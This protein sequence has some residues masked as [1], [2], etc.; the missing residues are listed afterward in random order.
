[1]QEEMLP[2]DEVRREL[3]R[4]LEAAECEIT[5]KAEREGRQALRRYMAFPT[6]W[7]VY[8]YALQHLKA[9]FPLHAVP[10]GD[11]PGSRGVGYEM[12]NVDG[13]GLYIKLKLEDGRAWLISCHY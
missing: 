10:Q 4:Q 8:N 3:I 1:M 2:L 9:N 12:R 13:Q 6:Q 11:P 5:E 7:A